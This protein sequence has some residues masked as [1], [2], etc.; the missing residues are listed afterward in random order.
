MSN[1]AHSRIKRLIVQ[2]TGSIAF[3]PAIIAV[4]F[5]L[6]F[7]GMITLDDSAT[8]K[9]IRST[10]QWLRMKDAATARLVA[11]TIAG[12][13]LSF[14]VFSFSMVMIAL[15]QTA[16]KMSNR[17]LETIIRNRFQQVVLGCYIGTV[18]YS[19]FLVTAIRDTDSGIYVPA[20]S[21]FL[22]I[23]F[24]IVDIFL[25]IYFLHFV[26]QYAKYQTIIHHKLICTHVGG[27]PAL[28][29]TQGL[30]RSYLLFSVTR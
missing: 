4:A 3:C 27:L 10:W 5:L 29:S 21:T 9:H 7:S 6:T 24:A 13:M 23:L 26:T 19:L 18:I 25:F 20:I 11:S 16:S 12:G 2:L 30:D 8:G 14:T 22:L 28:Y 1:V 15:N 17:I